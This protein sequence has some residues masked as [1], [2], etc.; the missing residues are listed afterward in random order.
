MNGADKASSPCSAASVTS[1]A[2]A[3][4]AT[5]LPGCV[6]EKFRPAMMPDQIVSHVDAPPLELEPVVSGATF[7]SYDMPGTRPY[8]TMLDCT[9]ASDVIATP[10]AGSSAPRT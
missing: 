7:P 10:C 4:A 5:G 3:I 6:D 2:P 8:P 9:D 1:P